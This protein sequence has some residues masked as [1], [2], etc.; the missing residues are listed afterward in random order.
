MA[1]ALFYVV[2]GRRRTIHRGVTVD[3]VDH[4]A[5]ERCNLDDTEF[6]AR[7][8]DAPKE[9]DRFCRWCFPGGRP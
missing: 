7:R 5:T 4:V 3:G 8:V 1:E 6:P 9:L 2:A